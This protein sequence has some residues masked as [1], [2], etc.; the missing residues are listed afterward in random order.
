M[1][2][3]G[4]WPGG[5]C[6][7]PNRIRAGARVCRKQ[8]AQVLSRLV[9]Q[10]P[11]LQRSRDQPDPGRFCQSLRSALRHRH[12]PIFGTR[13]NRINGAGRVHQYEESLNS[14]IEYRNPKQIRMTEIQ[15]PD[16][17]AKLVSVFWY[18]DF[19]FVSSFGFRIW[20]LISA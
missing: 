4:Y 2:L 8:V 20:N 9:P 12:R 5:L 19:G 16:C 11:R 18:L 14:N 13:R 15:N 3:S 10:C 7:D 17:A 6:P 1:P